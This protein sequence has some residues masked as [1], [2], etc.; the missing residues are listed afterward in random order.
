MGQRVALVTGGVGGIGTEI[1]HTLAKAG[2]KTGSTYAS[3][4]ANKIDGWQKPLKA[5]GLDVQLFEADVSDFA[6]CEKMA[7]AVEEKMGPVDILVNCAGITRDSTLKKMPVE[8]WNLVIQVNLNSVFNVTRQFFP[9]M[10]DRNWGRII[11]IASMNGQKGMFGQSNYAATKGGMHGFTMS[12][13]QEGAR[14]AVTA[15][16]ISPGYT[17]TEMMLAIPEK[18]MEGIKKGIPMQ[19]LA[20]PRE[21]AAAVKFLASDDAAYITGVNLDVNGGMWMHH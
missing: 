1:V 4:E 9:G 7:K 2:Y 20:E 10:L 18:V 11:N 19:R 17:A 21:I 8:N 3:F 12:I 13:A 6:S 15:N 14:N 5:E 16:C